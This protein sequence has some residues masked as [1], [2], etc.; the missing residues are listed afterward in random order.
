MNIKPTISNYIEPVTQAI[1]E[2]HSDPEAWDI[3][4]QTLKDIYG[5]NNKLDWM[6]Y[7]KLKSIV[8]KS[9]KDIEMC[10][11][12]KKLAQLAFQTSLINH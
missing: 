9:R 1:T 6:S 8:R 12:R 11:N 7:A 4:M 10:E 3:A 2:Y 5:M